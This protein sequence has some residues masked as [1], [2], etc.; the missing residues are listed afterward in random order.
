[1]SEMSLILLASKQRC[2]GSWSARL[3]GGDGRETLA[4]STNMPKEVSKLYHYGL[5]ALE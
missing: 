1:M 5:N 4:V 2:C 3:H